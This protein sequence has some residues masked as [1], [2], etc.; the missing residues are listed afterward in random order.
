[1]AMGLMLATSG[2]ILYLPANTLPPYLLGLLL[3]IGFG[4]AMIP[5][6]VIKEVNPDNAKG[7]AT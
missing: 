2:T 5:Y 7:S 4:T 1:M 3:G 6:T